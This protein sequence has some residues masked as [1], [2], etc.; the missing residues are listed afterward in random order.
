MTLKKSV[1]NESCGPNFMLLLL[2][3]MVGGPGIPSGCAGWS[4]LG[5]RRP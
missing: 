1:I 5:P 2:L 3:L 4:V